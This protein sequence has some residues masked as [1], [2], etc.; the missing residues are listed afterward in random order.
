MQ[1]NLDFIKKCMKVYGDQTTLEDLLIILNKADYINIYTDGATQ[2]DGTNRKSGIGIYFGD[3]RNLAKLID[4]KDNNECEIIACIEALKIVINKFDFVN[5]LTDSRLIVDRMNGIC[6][7]SKCKELFDELILLSDSFL[8]V[9]FIWIKGH[10]DIQ[11]NIEA[12]KLSRL[13][14]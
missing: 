7:S 8:D 6:R 9:K 4:T 13:L 12:D 2:F 3:E 14:L 11:G 1:M 5:I 10:S